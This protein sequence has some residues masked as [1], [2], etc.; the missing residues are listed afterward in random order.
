MTKKQIIEAL[1]VNTH[2]TYIDKSRDHEITAL[3]LLRI[4]IPYSVL[5]RIIEKVEKDLIV[6]NVPLD[7]GVEFLTEED[8]AILADCNLATK[9]DKFVLFI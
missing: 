5:P 9:N 8:I 4:K 6:T 1:D 2:K 7:V 3:H